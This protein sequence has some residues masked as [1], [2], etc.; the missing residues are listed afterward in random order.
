MDNQMVFL[1]SWLFLISLFALIFECGRAGWKL[2]KRYKKNAFLFALAGVIIS[3]VISRGFFI[4]V[5]FGIQ[6]SNIAWVYVVMAVSA[7]CCIAIYRFVN[8]KLHRGEEKQ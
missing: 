5:R 1:H 3:I 4:L 6:G 2:A 7:V 8:G